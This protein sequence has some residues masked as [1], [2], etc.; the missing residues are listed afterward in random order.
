MGLSGLQSILAV[1][2]FA[3]AAG[4][5]DGPPIV[6]TSSGWLEGKQWS[7]RGLDRP[8]YTYLG[9]P[10]AKPPVGRLRF[11]EPVA[12]ETW[13]GTRKATSLPQGCLQDSL[14]EDMLA[15]FMKIETN[16]RMYTEDC[17]YLNVFTPVPPHDTKTKLSVMVWI[18]GGGFWVGSGKFYDGSA[19]AA[20]EDVVVVVIQYRLGVPGFLSTGDEHLRAN[21]GMLDQIAALKWIQ[22]N[23]KSFG[24]DPSSVTIFGE[25]AGGISVSLLLVSPLAT[26]LFH[27][28][29]SESGTSLIRGLINTDLKA[30]TQ[31]IANKTGC[32]TETSLKFVSCLRNLSEEEMLNLTKI[33]TFAPIVVDGSFLSK[34]AEH[35]L[36]AKEV[37]VVPYLLGVN[38]HEVGWILAKIFNPPGWE[39]GMDRETS[40]KINRATR[41]LTEEE[42]Q[43]VLDEYM[44]D[45]Q[46]R[47]KIRDLHLEILGDVLMLVPTIRS[48]RLSR[49]AGSPVFLYEF[50]HR[51]S[52]Y[53]ETRPD[54]VKADHG[55]EV[56]YVLGSSF[57]N[58]DIIVTV[59]GTAEEVDLSRR[60]MKYWA[61]FAKNGNPN[62]EGLELWPAYDQDESYMQLNLK[63]KAGT[64]L[65]EHRVKFFTETL[66]F[67]V[68]KETPAGGTCSGPT[69]R[70]EDGWI[71]GKQMEVEGGPRLVLGFLGVPFAAAPV[72]PLRFAAPQRPQPWKGIRNA[73]S[74]PPM[75]LQ[76]IRRELAPF[77]VPASEDCLYLSVYCPAEAMLHHTTV[78]VMVWIHGGAFILGKGSIFYGSALASFGNVVVVVI[79]YRLSLAGFLSTGDEWARGNFGFLDQIAALEWVQRNIKQF[80]GNPDQVTLFGES[81]GGLSVSLHTLSPLSAD[82]FNQAIL[83]SG[84]ALMPGLLP[85]LPTQLANEAA[86]IAGCTNVQS[87]LLLQ[88]LKNKTEEE[89]AQI[90]NQLNDNYQIIPIVVDGYFLPDDP[91][92]MFQDGMFRKMPYLLGVTNE[93]GVKSLVHPEV[94][95]KPDW[96]AAGIT[97]DEIREKIDMYLK[98]LFGA[99]NGGP[100]FDEYFKDVHSPDLLKEHYL[101]LFGDVYIAIP[102]LRAAQYY[103]GAGNPVFLYEFQHRASFYERRIPQF[104][105]APHGAELAF[106]FGGSF[107]TDFDVLLGNMTEEEKK[108]SQAVMLYWASFAWS[109][110]P[111]VTGQPAWPVNG[112][113]EEFMQLNLT[114][115]VDYR[116]KADK[117]QF[118][119]NKPAK[120]IAKLF[121]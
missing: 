70:T 81:V 58:G 88:C 101:D 12:P 59:N 28:A 92:K 23:I 62:G 67:R 42:F 9:I 76:K 120:R 16:L 96:E 4:A 68:S 77:A 83:Q 110:R 60:L 121:I 39:E 25:S 49:D 3:S 2:A 105:R 63:P 18:H 71:R 99:E 37:N 51:T 108:L 82:L 95:I 80:G 69:V 78:P 22:G 29:I 115:N 5:K 40:A 45:T 87:Q 35:L 116:L 109:G 6:V 54:F 14:L 79:Q 21:L 57:W 97:R 72:G 56:G 46:D 103:R 41:L 61:N 19:L 15:D 112:D 13:N 85:P 91:Q 66:R 32:G 38:N 113:H 117:I 20:Y 36:E 48:A 30:T 44:G 73:T 11:S 55:D 1:L 111:N 27:R 31:M 34:E 47:I 98:P 26:G 50:Q 104:T 10:Y 106:V 33:N 114:L 90:I 8:V 52:I 84:S 86:E 119:L 118:W 65:K 107:I 17:L 53:N 74:H 94:I 93:E 102:T 24:G 7:V 64:K 89:M 100:I 43:H 75:C